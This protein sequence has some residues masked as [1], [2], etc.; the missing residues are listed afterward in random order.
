MF[1]QQKQAAWSVEKKKQPC[2]LCIDSSQHN[3]SDIQST[4][5]VCVCVWVGF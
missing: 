3:V 5:F 4:A 2:A 1:K